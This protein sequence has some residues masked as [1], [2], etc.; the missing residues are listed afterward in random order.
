MTSYALARTYSH[1]RPR[2][3][4]RAHTGSKMSNR[5]LSLDRAFLLH[6][7]IPESMPVSVPPAAPRT[8]L[9]SFSASIIVTAGTLCRRDAA[10][11]G[12]A[13]ED[14]LRKA[15]LALGLEASDADM[16]TLFESLDVTGDD[17]FDVAELPTLLRVNAPETLLRSMQQAKFEQALAGMRAEEPGAPKTAKAAE[18]A[19]EK[20][21]DMVEAFDTATPAE[22]SAATAASVQQDAAAPAVPA[23]ACESSGAAAAEARMVD[24]DEQASGGP[25]PDV[26]PDK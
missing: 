1:L 7:V 2:A 11:S 26:S 19:E 10:G 9:S 16:H 17:T 6:S 23:V 14:E 25:A 5:N 22:T 20:A 15:L 12:V 4:P 18:A 8:A 13:T 3:E 24:V 21:A